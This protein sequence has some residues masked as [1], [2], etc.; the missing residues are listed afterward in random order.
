MAKESIFLEAVDG[1]A[2]SINGLVT[3]V[4]G[5]LDH[6]ANEKDSYSSGLAGA[7]LDKLHITDAFFY[8]QNNAAALQDMQLNLSR[9]IGETKSSAMSIMGTALDITTGN[10][11]DK[12][13]GFAAQDYQQALF[14]VQS[15]LGRRIGGFDTEGATAY[16][17]GDRLFG[18]S[19]KTMGEISA[20]F[21]QLGSNMESVGDTVGKMFKDATNQG[22][23]FQKIASTVKSHLKEAN[24]YG[25]KNGIEGMRQMAEYAEQIGMDMSQV[26]KASTRMNSLTGVTDIAAK[27]S[28]LGGNFQRLGNPLEML[29]ESLT[30]V[31]SLQKRIGDMFQ[32]MAKFDAKKGMISVSALDRMRINEAAS[33][34]GL[35]PSEVFKSVETQARRSMIEKQIG[36]GLNDDIKNLLANVGT[37]NKEG[38]AGYNIDGKFYDVSEIASSQALQN[39]IKEENMTDS[40]NISKIA[41]SLRSWKQASMDFYTSLANKKTLVEFGTKGELLTQSERQ[42][43]D[44]INS[45]YSVISRVISGVENAQK[46]ATEGIAD[47]RAHALSA[48]EGVVGD[49]VKVVLTPLSDKI[50]EV[51]AQDNSK[52]STPTP[53][54]VAP[55]NVQ[56]N[57]SYNEIQPIT[58]QD[59]TVVIIPMEKTIQPTPIAET[60]NLMNVSQVGA[61]TSNN[62][63][64]AVSTP[65]E[66]SLSAE[67]KKY[68]EEEFT[69]AA[70][71]IYEKLEREKMAHASIK[72]DGSYSLG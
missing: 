38:R 4:V 47:I 8:L 57:L 68:L 50:N 40:E 7:V 41:Q 31:E 11:L 18:D 66:Y 27:L 21:L 39:K 53:S 64:I 44:E 61:Q 1:L 42:Y 60:T 52:V 10:Q 30:D 49:F 69:S 72:K 17:A 6:K 65:P 13:F 22:L 54:K 71:K 33:A 55:V 43:N 24:Q 67:D 36:I 9:Q 16:A 20:A 59:S 26:L 5:A 28:V 37:I 35:D 51:K 23:S 46:L 70:T 19:G 63:N 25:F 62:I 3:E 58:S 2:S 32:G 56:H 15:Q 14:N 12:K 34:M 45:P 29:N 48:I